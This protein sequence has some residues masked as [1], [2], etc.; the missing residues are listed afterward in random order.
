MKTIRPS[1]HHNTNQIN[2]TDKYKISSY[3]T[4]YSNL[5]CAAEAIAH[6]FVGLCGTSLLERPDLI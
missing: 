2:H 4:I 1:V 5:T 3:S 6:L